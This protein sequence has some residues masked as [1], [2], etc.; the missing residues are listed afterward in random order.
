MIKKGLLSTFALA[1]L[2]FLAAC[3]TSINDN[4]ATQTGNT[5]SSAPSSTPL[6][7]TEQPGSEPT[8]SPTSNAA[9]GTADA[10]DVKIKLKFMDEEVIVKLFDNP[11]SQDFLSRLP[12]SLTFEEF[13]GF[14]K[15]SILEDGLS[16]EGASEGYTPEAGDFAYY[17]PWK[18]VTIF[19]ADW[20]YSPGLVKLGEV[21]SGVEEL[22]EKL[23]TINEDFTIVIEKMD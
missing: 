15:M 17:A 7:A 16:I 8:S 1:M 10:E 2:L 3:D 22:S 4:A 18:D 9:A 21:E 19:Y 23:K 5:S 13:G 12:L 6:Q 20:K 11:T 14:E